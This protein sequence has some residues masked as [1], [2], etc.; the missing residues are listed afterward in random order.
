MRR[1][2][3][4][5]P[6]ERAVQRAPADPDVQRLC[7]EPLPRGFDDRDPI[8][9]CDENPPPAFAPAS[10][11]AFAL[12]WQPNVQSQLYGGSATHRL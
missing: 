7:A 10:A 1:R 4:M 12:A 9:V 5:A 2:V 3:G 11:R 6:T 8:I